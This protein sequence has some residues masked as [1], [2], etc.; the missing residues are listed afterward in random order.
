MI[1]RVY[2]RWKRGDSSGAHKTQGKK[3]RQPPPFRGRP[4]AA[5]ARRHHLLLHLGLVEPGHALVG[6]LGER[7]ATAQ[8][9]PRLFRNH[10]AL[11]IQKN[12]ALG[13]IAMEISIPPPDG[14]AHYSTMIILADL[15]QCRAP[16]VWRFHITVMKKSS[17]SQVD[18]GL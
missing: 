5:R 13:S 2:A 16:K 4:A 10:R 12:F 1:H 17:R 14:G 6:L 18:L 9:K 3:H 15:L 7:G 11:P 8:R